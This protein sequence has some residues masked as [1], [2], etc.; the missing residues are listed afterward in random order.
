MDHDFETDKISLTAHRGVHG[1]P[2]KKA[3]AGHRRRP[4]CER[5]PSGTRYRQKTDGTR[6]IPI[7]RLVKSGLVVEAPLPDEIRYCIS[8]SGAD[9]IT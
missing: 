3:F 2:D 8:I 4:G 7:R 1:R 6:S 9:Y 5:R